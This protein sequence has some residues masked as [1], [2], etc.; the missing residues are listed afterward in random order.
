[1]AEDPDV[2]LL[3][4][5]VALDYRLG[6]ARSTGDLDLS[7]NISIAA[8]TEKLVQAVATDLGDH[9]EV[10][11]SSAPFRPVDE[12]ETYRFQLDVRLNNKIFVKISIDIGFADPWIGEAES[13]TSETLVFAGAQPVVVRAIPI[14]Q[15]I[16]EKIHAYTKSY[17]GHPSSRV[18]DLVDLVLLLGYRPLR[19]STLLFAIDTVFRNRNSHERPQNLP[20]PPPGWDKTY[21]KLSETLPITHDVTEAFRQVASF[22]DP[23]LADPTKEQWWDPEARAWR[24]GNV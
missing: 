9:F 17:N 1:M 2:W 14:E 3:K 4:G 13:L 23:M 24:A 21:E 20:P 11:V 8:F 15:H 22:L 18:K 7:S 12:V 6:E 19:A 5:G 16:A 10:R